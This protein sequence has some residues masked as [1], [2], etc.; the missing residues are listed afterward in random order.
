MTIRQTVQ[1]N[2]VTPLLG[3]DTP[4]AQRYLIACTLLSWLGFFGMALLMFAYTAA[5]ES[6][7]KAVILITTGPTLVGII[8]FPIAIMGGFILSLIDLLE[9]V[10]ATTSLS[11]LLLFKLVGSGSYLAILLSFRSTRVVRC[12][13][14]VLLGVLLL[15]FG[16]KF[17]SNL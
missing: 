9:S 12:F 8:L 13:G 17:I 3:R 1:D 4:S 10:G 14:G 16:F 7:L 5:M 15:S 6:G 11:P 2:L